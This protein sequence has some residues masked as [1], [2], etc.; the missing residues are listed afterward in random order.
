LSTPTEIKAQAIAL[1]CL[2]YS[3]RN[4]EKQLKAKFPGAAVPRYCTISRWV[5]SRPT[6]R[7]ALM[8]WYDAAHMAAGI[9]HDRMDE[10]E[11]VPFMQVIRAYSRTMDI[12]LSWHEV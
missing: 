12:T 2:G 9:L 6:K 3:C 8:Q 11:T 4:I 10:L 1:H 5:R 7:L